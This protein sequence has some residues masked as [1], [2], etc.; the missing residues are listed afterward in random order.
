MNDTV[1]DDTTAAVDAQT[2]DGGTIAAIEAANTEAAASTA[3]VDGETGNGGDV[4]AEP[5]VAPELSSGDLTEASPKLAETSDQNPPNPEAPALE[6]AGDSVGEP[7]APVAP[8]IATG[9]DD[10]GEVIGVPAP[11]V[12]PGTLI[13]GVGQPDHV[14]FRAKLA[15]I[16]ARLEIDVLEDVAALEKKLGDYSV[17][18]LA[19]IAALKAEH[20]IA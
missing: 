2:N 3:P 9:I 11:E 12:G 1:K 14:G 10:G 4:S 16:A 5:S 13:P 20:N 19:E 7:N 15:D 6:N 17:E 18:T 8:A